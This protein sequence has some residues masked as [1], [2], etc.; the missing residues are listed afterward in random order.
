MTARSITTTTLLA[1]F[2]LFT[3]ACS[4]DSGTSSSYPWVGQSFL[5]SVPADRWTEPAGIGSDIGNF[6]PNF[7]IEVSSVSDGSLQA[8]LGTADDNGAQ[9]LCNPTTSITG[10][11]QPPSVQIGPAEVPLRIVDADHGVVVTAMAHD[12]TLTNILPDGDVMATEGE[13]SAT[14]DARE[15]Y[16]LFYLLTNPTPD[17]VCSALLSFGAACSACPG[18]GAAYCLSLKAVRLGATELTGT[19]LQPVDAA[20]LD[21]SC[22]TN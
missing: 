6:V 18:D 8:N 11:A 20:S 13:L 5:L 9:D 17:V 10:T 2:P 3:L 19:N 12:F 4:S 21:S 7:I 22:Q 15:L 14:V 1:L 16:P